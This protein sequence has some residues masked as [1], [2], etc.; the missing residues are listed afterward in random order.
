MQRVALPNLGSATGP[1]DGACCLPN[2]RT[3]RLRCAGRFPDPRTAPFVGE[4]TAN[5]Q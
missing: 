4:F 5:H 2:Q 1:E 3:G